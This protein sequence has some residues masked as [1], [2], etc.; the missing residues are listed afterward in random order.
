[1]HMCVLVEGVIICVLIVLVAQ[2]QDC[3]AGSGL[4]PHVACNVGQS[5]P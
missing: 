1:M 3:I 4:H 5:K 2:S